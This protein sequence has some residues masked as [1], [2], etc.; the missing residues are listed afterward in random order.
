[1]YTYIHIYVYLLRVV[2]RLYARK[3]TEES[4]SLSRTMDAGNIFQTV[5]IGL[6]KVRLRDDKIFNVT[7][8][9]WSFYSFLFH[10]W[11]EQKNEDWSI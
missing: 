9:I 5:G 10:F 1:M 6:K 3:N 11:G 2:Q 8:S 4:S 7:P